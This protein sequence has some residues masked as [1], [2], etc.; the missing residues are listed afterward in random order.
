MSQDDNHST[1]GP[2]PPPHTHRPQSTISSRRQVMAAPVPHAAVSASG[3]G[4]QSQHSRSAPT[5]QSAISSH[6]REL[7]TGGPTPAAADVSISRISAHPAFSNQHPGSVTMGRRASAGHA[8]R[9]PSHHCQSPWAGVVCD[10]S[11]PGR[12]TL[13]NGQGAHHS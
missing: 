5:P 7:E 1:A 11:P 9:P 8:C 13:D 4:R 2:P 6:R 10:A 12:S 3:T